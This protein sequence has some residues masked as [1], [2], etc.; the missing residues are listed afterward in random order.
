LPSTEPSSP[1][2]PTTARRR[3]TPRRVI[4]AD[5]LADRTIRVGGVLVIV[6]IFGIMIFLVAEVLPLFR[7]GAIVA[8]MQYRI[9]DGGQRRLLAID[10][11]DGM[12]VEVDTA[13]RF[14]A[15]HVGTGTSVPIE[16]PAVEGI[17]LTTV[18]VA[19]DG[20]NFALGTADGRILLGEVVFRTTVLPRERALARLRMLDGR[21]GLDGSRFYSLLSSG[22]WRRT[23]ASVRLAEPLVA[24]SDGAALLRLALRLSGT[25]ERREQNLLSLDAAG[26]LR[27]VR[28]RARLNLADGSLEVLPSVAEI[29]TLREPERVAEV[30]VSAR[31]DQ[32][33]VAHRDGAVERFLVRDLDKVQRVEEKRLLP[34]GVSL[35]AANFLLGDQTLLVAG[36]DGSLTGW[37]LLER[38]EE[39]AA[40][41]RAL[42]PAR[43][44]VE[45][46]SAIVRLVPGQRSKSFLAADAAGE[47]ALWHATSERRLLTLPGLGSGPRGLLFSPREDAVLALGEDGSA[48]H[49]RIAVP[50]PE[51]N[52]RTLFGKVWYEGF[53]EP[54]YVW[55]SSAGSDDF[56]PKLSLVPLVFGTFK[57]TLYALLFAVPI[58][59]AAAVYTSEFL[60]PR[61]RNLIKPAIETMAAL[62]S[63]VLGFIAALVLSPWVENWVLAVLLAFLVV[64]VGLLLGG[65]LWQALPWQ[66]SVHARLL[67]PL[68][69][70]AVL[71]LAVGAAAGLAPVLEKAFF[72]GDFRAWL[73]GAGEGD[74]ALLV[75]LLLPLGLILAWW[76]GA[77]ILPARLRENAL[78]QLGFFAIVLAGSGILA[79]L[80][81]ELLALLGAEARGGVFGPYS[82]RNTLVVAFAMGFAVIPLIYTIAEDALSS[83]PEHLRAASLALGATPWQTA[84]RVILPT[85]FSGIFAAVMIGMG[86]AVGETMIVVMAAGNTPL[87]DWNLFNGFRALSA[88]IAVELPEA[89]RGGTLY[90]VLF[91]AGLVLFVLTFVLNTLAEAIRLRFRRRAAQL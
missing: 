39:G 3:P 4:L 14:S 50:H 22:E 21:D 45:A 48:R 68:M 91:L 72:A 80:G 33:L 19:P 11:Y 29:A 87:L 1:G 90:R 53:P 52:L 38:A 20:R 25:P 62:P 46:G 16:A 70:V 54:A 55:Q 37:F 31:G 76:A 77:R 35:S 7:G 41:G 56:E 71:M 58:A 26:R 69:F 47:V 84:M 8:E 83:V 30:L 89:V 28:A 6:A 63:V 34:A 74:R 23:Q 17:G 79:L 81:A 67:R 60:S 78:G 59:L 12:A 85:A 36:E 24:S 49:W 88:N 66:R 13:G 9:A 61:A 51:T 82:Q 65:F 32:V 5:R 73:G 27:L 18:T 40:D 10:E 42:V 64:P 44:F 2:E 75:G 57:G 86:R 43:R 15:F